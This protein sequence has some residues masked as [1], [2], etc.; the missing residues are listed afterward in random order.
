MVSPPWSGALVVAVLLSLG[1]TA[2]ATTVVPLDEVQLERAADLV[3]EG[4]VVEAF[5]QWV[6]RRILTFYRV[7][8]PTADGRAPHL[9]TVAV[10]GGDVDGVSQ[11]VAGAPVL[12]VGQRYRLFLGAA[13]G[14]APAANHPNSRG[15]IG[16]FQG[17]VLLDGGRE[18][19]FTPD[20]HPALR[21]ITP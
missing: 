11:R 18:V 10:P 19:P 1:P 21:T 7:S 16:F 20:G 8:S 15:I 13:T 9:T 4:V 17:V 12:V 6:G 3:V 2:T 14:P 5:S